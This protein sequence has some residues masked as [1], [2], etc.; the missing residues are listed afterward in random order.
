MRENCLN[1]GGSGSGPWFQTASCPG[2]QITH[3]HLIGEDNT[4]TERRADFFHARRIKVYKADAPNPGTVRG[5]QGGTG[6]FAK[7][8]KDAKGVE[9]TLVRIVVPVELKKRKARQNRSETDTDTDRA[10]VASRRRRRLRAARAGAG[11][12]GRTWRRSTR[13]LPP[14]SLVLFILLM[15]SRTAS[16]TNARVRS[17]GGGGRKIHHFVAPR[18][19][20]ETWGARDDRK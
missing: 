20:L 15:R 11:A 5:G 14:C 4:V 18:T 2:M 9:I 1:L 16:S 17:P 10:V 6:T 19:C 13:P 8:G 3:L 12:D 7:R